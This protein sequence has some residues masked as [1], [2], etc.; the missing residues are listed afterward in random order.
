MIES[1]MSS[2]SDIARREILD[3]RGNPSIKVDVALESDV[4]GRA[5]VPS[6][7]RTGEHDALELRFGDKARCLGKGISKAVKSVT[8]ISRRSDN[9]LLRIEQLLGN[10]AVYDGKF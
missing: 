3:S 7:A 8:D 9:Q 10:N 5:L 4:A 1:D 6:G 2:V